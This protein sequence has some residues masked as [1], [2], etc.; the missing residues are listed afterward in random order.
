[1]KKGLLSLMFT[2]T[3]AFFATAQ[4][5]PK[6]VVRDSVATPPNL[7]QLSLHECIQV[8]LDN[9]LTVKRGVYNVETN[10]VN[11]LQAEGLFLPTLSA[12]SSF[13]QNYGRNLNPVTYQYFNGVTRTIN[14][15]IQGSLTLFNGLRIFRNFQSNQKFLKAADLDLEKAKNDVIINVATDYVTVILNQELYENARV[16]LLSSQQQLDKI[17]KQ[18]EAGALSRSNEMN[19]EA[20]VATNETNLITQENQLNY[21]LL[22]LKQAMQVPASNQFTVI[23]PDL[24]LEDLVI[25]Q[26]PEEIYK[27]SSQTLPQIKSALLK[28]DAAQLALQSTRGAY[29]PR[30]TLSAAETSNYSS[31]SNQ[32]QVKYDPGES[33]SVQPVGQTASGEPIYAY[34]QNSHITSNSYGVK[35]QLQNNIYKNLSLTLS[36]PILNGFTTRGNVQQ[37]VINREL[38][39]ITVHETENTL[40]QSIETAY[41]N[42][43]SA[44]KTY[45]AA[46]KQVKYSEEAYRMTKQRLDNGAANFVEYQIS[47]NDLF[48]A[49]STL[50]RAKFNFLLTKKTLDFYQG[51]S[52]EY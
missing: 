33:L 7:P 49:R 29:Y 8:A 2:G 42:A 4:D 17:K 13:G 50:S 9:N 3:V 41:N 35:D 11:L 20:I 38:A 26:T 31:A 45:A 6:I 24:A 30:V 25:D 27:I 51:K 18:V 46:V 28:V 32:P 43:I 23:I 47:A 5:Q 1:M 12:S 52:I 44:A 21:S 34:V 48:S 37:A 19:Q 16:Q 40:R 39:N 10:R 36:I 14:P 15:I 22:I